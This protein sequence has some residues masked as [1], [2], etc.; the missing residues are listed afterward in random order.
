MPLPSWIVSVAPTNHTDTNARIQIVFRSD[1]LAPGSLENTEHQILFSHMSLEPELPGH[2]IALTPRMISY[3]PDV[4]FPPATLFHVTLI[5]GL[6]DQIGDALDQ[7]YSWTFVT[8][9]KPMNTAALTPPLPSSPPSAGHMFSVSQAGT[10]IASK[11]AAA[12]LPVV[13]SSDALSNVGGLD[14]L[15]SNTVL[16]ENQEAVR[17][18]LGDQ[19]P[20]ATAVAARIRVAADQIV[21][22]RRY[23]YTSAVPELQNQ[24]RSALDA[25][26][27]VRRDDG[28]YEEWPGAGS[29]DMRATVFCAVSLARARAAGA[30]VASALEG[31]RS[32][33]LSRL[34]SRALLQTAEPERS[35]ERLDLLEGLG[36][37]GTVRKDH[38]DQI[39][40]Q[41]DRLSF[42]GQVELARHLLRLPAWHARGAALRK[43]LIEQAYLADRLTFIGAGTRQSVPARA[44]LVELLADSPK[45][46]AYMDIA[47]RTLLSLRTNGSWG[48][49]EDNAEA[50][51]AISAYAR[52]Q[53]VLPT[54]TASV[55]IGDR[56]FSADFQGYRKSIA[57]WHLP[58]SELP[59]LSSIVIIRK[60]GVGILHYDVTYHYA[61]SGEQHGRYEGLRVERIVRAGSDYTE[62]GRFGLSPP[63]APLKLDIQHVFEI[64]DTIVTDHPVDQIVLDDPL[65]PG[66]VTVNDRV[67]G[68]EGPLDYVRVE[69]G[70]LMVFVRHMGVGSHFIRYLAYSATPGTFTWPSARAYVRSGQ[71]EYGLTAEGQVL[72]LPSPNR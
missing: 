71:T 20:F 18:T 65:P 4:P 39:Y 44:H 27:V 12:L 26:H 64:E 47:M 16:P 46:L 68:D 70:R 5:K 13:I 14:V 49:S 45:S 34:K 61:V 48:S 55:G 58:M 6:S 1:I 38:L 35:K 17:V 28:G 67:S 43:R 41:R 7:N 23:G 59:R 36:A 57:A 19:I 50:S 69:S 40:A 62:L 51:D 72:I 31:L 52:S 53:E 30:D 10:A 33:F 21:L 29:T 8:D 25:L 15:L 60:E 63:S 37:V 9:A 56:E 32:F 66:L 54:F 22:D 42:D 24:L 11:G 3:Q 2:F